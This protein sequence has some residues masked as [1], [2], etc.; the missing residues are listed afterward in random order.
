MRPNTAACRDNDISE[1][2]RPTRGDC[3]L[4][5]PGR[6]TTKWAWC[7]VEQHVWHFWQT[8]HTQ[9]QTPL[10][11]HARAHSR[12]HTHTSSVPKMIMFMFC[13]V[14]HSFSADNLKSRTSCCFTTSSEFLSDAQI[15][16][17]RLW[18]KRKDFWSCWNLP[19]KVWPVSFAS[20]NVEF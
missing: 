7:W 17:F 13:E 9:A 15:L 11:T 16:V 14:P 19:A 5:I 8:Y 20:K 12:T 2:Q 6:T 4:Q 10:H 1:A 3:S 18:G